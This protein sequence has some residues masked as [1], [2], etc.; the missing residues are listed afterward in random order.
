MSFLEI[1]VIFF[2]TSSN[3]ILITSSLILGIN[4]VTAL[5]ILPNSSLITFRK[6]VVEFTDVINS[7]KIFLCSGEKS[8]Y[9][10]LNFS[11]NILNVSNLRSLSYFANSCITESSTSDLFTSLDVKC[12]KI[13]VLLFTK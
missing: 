13:V 9:L 1:G 4:F 8:L 5:D 2:A 6:R 12:S 7:L 11:N 10:S 3:F